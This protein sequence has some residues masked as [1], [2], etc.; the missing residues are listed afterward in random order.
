MKNF[1]GFALAERSKGGS[2][3]TVIDPV[4]SALCQMFPTNGLLV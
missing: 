2:Q 4:S 3:L 1:Q